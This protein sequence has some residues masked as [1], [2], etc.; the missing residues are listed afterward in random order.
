MRVSQTGSTTSLPRS[1]GGWAEEISLDIDMVS[2]ICPNCNLALVEASSSSLSALGTAEDEAAKLGADEISNSY[3]GSESPSDTTYDIEYYDHPG[4][5]ITASSGD[6]GYGVG[7]PAASQYVTA[8]G[9]TTLNRSTSPFGTRRSEIR[10]L[11]PGSGRPLGSRRTAALLST[12]T[13]ADW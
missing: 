5:A 11:Q 8:V 2:A 6:D 4:I 1:N 10:A 13:Y 9:G 3:A 12:T 7:Y